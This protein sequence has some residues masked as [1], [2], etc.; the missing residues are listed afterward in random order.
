MKLGVFLFLLLFMLPRAAMADM[1]PY[2]WNP[3]TGK[4]EYDPDKYGPGD[5]GPLTPRRRPI[6]APDGDKEAEEKEGKAALLAM[7]SIL[8]VLALS[9]PQRPEVARPEVSG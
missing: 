7:V 3:A 8:G 6:H 5:P 1:P 4:M 2:T 9:R